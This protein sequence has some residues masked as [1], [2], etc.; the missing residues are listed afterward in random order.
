MSITLFLK[1]KLPCKPYGYWSSWYLLMVKCTNISFLSYGIPS[2]L[3]YSSNVR[4]SRSRE[5]LISSKCVFESRC[6][7]S[8]KTLCFS[9]ASTCASNLVFFNSGPTMANVSFKRSSL[10]SLYYS[11]FTVPQLAL[12]HLPLISAFSFT[13][14]PWA[15]PVK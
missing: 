4:V 9:I 11:G 13:V 10:L 2:T 6:N 5:L 15:S 3:R 1:N 12:I 14:L 7:F 8:S